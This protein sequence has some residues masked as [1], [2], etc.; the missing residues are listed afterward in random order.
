M[1]G[2]FWL[3]P[4]AGWPI[5]DPTMNHFIVLRKTWIPRLAK[6]SPMVL[7]GV[8]CFPAGWLG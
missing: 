2:D 1:G 4:L 3:H 8:C 7:I 5:G 6:F